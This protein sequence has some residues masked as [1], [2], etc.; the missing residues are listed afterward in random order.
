MNPNDILASIVFGG[1]GGGGNQITKVEELSTDGGASDAGKVLVVGDNGK[2]AAS[3]LTVGEGEIAVD[4]GLTVNGA[5]ADAKKTGD[6]I[7]ELNGSLNDLYESAD[8]LSVYGTVSNYALK[9]D[10]T[11]IADSDSEVKKYAVTEGDVIYLSLSGD[12]AT[13]YQFQNQAAIV[14]SN[15]SAVLVGRPVSGNVDAYVKV[16]TGA[17]YLI[18]SKLKTTD[19]NVVKRAINKFRIFDFTTRDREVDFSAYPIIPYNLYTSTWLAGSI[20]SYGSIMIP[21]SELSPVIDLEGGESYGIIYAFLRSDT[22]AANTRADFCV[23]ETRTREVGRGVQINNVRVPDDCKF[24][25]IYTGNGNAFFSGGS[26][27]TRKVGVA[28]Y[29]SDQVAYDLDNRIKD[30]IQIQS[31]ERLL[32]TLKHRSDG[33]REGSSGTGN[34]SDNLLVL[35]HVSDPHSDTH[36]YSRFIKF[37]KNHIDTINAGVVSGDFVLTARAEQFESMLACEDESVNLIKCTGNHDVTAGVTDEQVYNYLNLDTNTG[38]LYYYVDYPQGIRVICLH[39]YDVSD[40]SG[41]VR[42]ATANYSQTQ[43]DWFISTLQDALTNNLSVIVVA[44]GVHHGQLPLYNDKG[45]CQ[46]VDVAAAAETCPS[47]TIILDIVNAFKHGLSINQTYRGGALVA[48]TT[49]SSSGEFICYIGGH[50]HLDYIGYSRTYNDQLMCIIQ[51]CGI[52][53]NPN[54]KRDHD[55][56]RIKN[57]P[58]EES[59]N[60]YGFDTV[61]KLVKVVKIG[62]TLTDKFVERKYATFEY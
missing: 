50:L 46:D 45:F 8:D 10:G 1:D 41:A 49:F 32:R 3:D 11:Y 6:A 19:T 35:A 53:S 31:E 42:D 25:C 62:S 9:A 55:T 16:P 29:L 39:Q 61:S 52:D 5:A 54:F 18:V 57:T 14:A 56:P 44:H 2:I 38:K 60:V 47:G 12:N 27:I 30:L 20:T 7:A 22:A 26:K 34:V 37:L 59:I 33:I 13:T 48:N 23:G 43:I 51:V 36:V 24:L 17:T 40:A 15:P 21:A 28:G 4:K 58:T